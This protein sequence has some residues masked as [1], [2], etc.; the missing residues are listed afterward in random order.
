MC[1]FVKVINRKIENYNKAI[2]KSI[3]QDAQ[4][5]E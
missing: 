1:A 4:N 2:Q 5:E 3:G